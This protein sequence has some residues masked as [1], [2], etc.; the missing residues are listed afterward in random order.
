MITPASWRGVINQLYAFRSELH[1]SERA[2]DE[3]CSVVF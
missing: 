2:D 3:G 1:S